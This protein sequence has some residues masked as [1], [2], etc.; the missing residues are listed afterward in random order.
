MFMKCSK[1]K[2]KATKKE[3]KNPPKNKTKQNP[4]QKQFV[5]LCG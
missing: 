1:K 5:K 4:K 2:I 3:Q